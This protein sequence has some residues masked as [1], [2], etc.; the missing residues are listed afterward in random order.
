LVERNYAGLPHDLGGHDVD[1]LIR[2]E[3][4]DPALEIIKEKARNHNGRT[5]APRTMGDDLKWVITLGKTTAG[6]FWGVRFD[7]KPWTSWHGV[8]LEDIEAALAHS[9]RHRQ[10][11]VQDQDRA[12]FFASLENLLNGLP[13]SVNNYDQKLLLAYRR[14]PEKLTGLVRETLG[15]Q[16]DLMLEV[17]GRGEWQQLKGWRLRRLKFAMIGR[18]LAK[19]P[20]KIFYYWIKNYW[21]Y[22]VRVLDRVGV[23][24]V[25]LGLDGS[26]KTTL[27]QTVRQ[28]VERLL[29]TGSD[30]FYYRPHLIPYLSKLFGRE[31]DWVKMAANPHSEPPDG[32]VKSIIRLAYYTID[33]FLGYWLVVYPKM[34][35]RPRLVIFDRYFHVY[36]IDP[37]RS[38]IAAPPWLIWFFSYI[39]PRPDQFIFLT[40]NPEV[41]YQRKPEL[42]LAVLQGQSKKMY[43]LAAK[44]G[45]VTWVD[46]T[47]DISKSRQDML[48]AIF[49]AYGRRLKWQ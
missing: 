19:K 24:V 12:V 2:R 16:A 31:K 30:Y 42:P 4:I 29:H 23:F 38:K 13:P 34:V 11:R 7:L 27:C 28:D 5:T 21:N 17:M 44:L 49:E 46:S 8:Q 47:Q 33:Y 32:L 3:S 18:Q 45:H 14:S 41:S 25:V 20:G 36:F 9:F 6:E 1:I 10:I 22:L 26:G 48:E 15:K 43:D 37:A 35:K 40:P 39:V